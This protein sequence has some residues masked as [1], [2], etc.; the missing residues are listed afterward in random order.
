MSCL[1]FWLIADETQKGWLTLNEL[2]PLMEAFKFSHL[3]V[4]QYGKPDT[5]LTLKKLQTE[6]RF[7]LSKKR[8]ELTAPKIDGDEVIVR[9]DFVRDIFLER[10]L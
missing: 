5:A 6:F 1:T 8:Q 4:D 7:N 3:F 9:F 10:G 2:Q